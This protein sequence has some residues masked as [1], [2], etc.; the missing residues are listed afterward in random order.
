[1]IGQRTWDEFR[2]KLNELIHST[3]VRVFGAS[4]ICS[5]YP[6]LLQHIDECYNVASRRSH[7]FILDSKISDED[8]TNEEVLAKAVSMQ[9][10]GAPPTY[11][12]PKDY[13]WQQDRTTESVVEFLELWERLH[14]AGDLISQPL[15]PLQPTADTSGDSPTVYPT[16]GDHYEDM[17][18]AVEPWREEYDLDYWVIGGVA[19]AGPERQV[20]ALKEAR[21]AILESIDLHGLGMGGSLQLVKLLRE[22]APVRSIDL[23]SPGQQVQNAR[24]FDKQLKTHEYYYLRGDFASWVN[25]ML[26]FSMLLQINMALSPYCTDEI[27]NGGSNADKT[28]E[29]LRDDGQGGLEEW[30]T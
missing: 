16:H 29:E 8:I 18:E 9:E 6:Y 23:S 7:T 12:V 27:F 5:P 14:E 11:V 1:M 15:I 4:Y 21:E 19:K 28:P 13:L 20:E 17:V 26:E 25:G 10:A 2:H 24:I 22:E 30:S 3:P